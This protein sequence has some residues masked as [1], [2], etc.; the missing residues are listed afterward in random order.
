MKQ[1]NIS[2]YTDLLILDAL[3]SDE[4][5]MVKNAS[6]SVMDS[7]L[8][9]IKSYIQSAISSIAPGE[10]KL[11]AFVQFCT[12]PVLYKLVF[13]FTGSRM[14]GILVGVLSQVFDINLW[15]VI[16][17]IIGSIKSIVSSKG[18][19]TEDELKGSVHES[20]EEHNTPATEEEAQKLKDYAKQ[21][22]TDSNQLRDSRA[23]LSLELRKAK[24]L[25]EAL[26]VNEDLIKEACLK[27]DAG[28][29]SS[30]LEKVGYT[31]GAGLKN[32]KNILFYA[33]SFFLYGFGFLVAGDY[34]KK[35]FGITPAKP[36]A[37]TTGAPGMPG[38]PSMPGIPGTGGESMLSHLWNW[39]AGLTGH[40][41][42]STPDVHPTIKSET[43]K[44]FPFKK[45]YHHEKY[46]Q[47]TQ[48][49][50][51]KNV[52]NDVPEIEDL[53]IDFANDV[54][55]NLD[56]KEQIIV[57][58]PGFRAVKDDF[59]FYNKKLL[60]TTGFIIIPPQYK[61]KE[62]IANFFMDDVAEASEQKE[63]QESKPGA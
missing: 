37:A 54:Y 19:I 20:V 17:K 46:N 30:L 12:A 35:L 27:K 4:Q 11:S 25:R 52:H 13:G 58:T 31:K 8:Q 32:L 53:I 50:W 62:D 57:N 1:S 49:P 40:K 56:D 44:K 60:G 2:M 22:A 15:D 63:K 16:Q 55:E 24:L 48:S 28:I 3:L 59:I 14:L 38:M 34:L 33:L 6:A 41:K 45:S 18:S 10:D 61:S 42:E 51:T 23:S 9:N 43:L 21:H 7:I 26:L 47:S 5:S 29:L 36:A 39:F